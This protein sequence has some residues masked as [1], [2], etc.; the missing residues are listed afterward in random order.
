MPGA[1]SSQSECDWLTE[2][3]EIQG[4]ACTG[5]KATKASHISSMVP[6]FLAMLEILKEIAKESS[7]TEELN[8]QVS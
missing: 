8:Q 3:E 4:V 6:V 1:V 5:P 2:L 7:W